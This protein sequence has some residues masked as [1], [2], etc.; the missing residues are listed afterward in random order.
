MSWKD[1]NFWDQIS[2]VGLL[3]TL[4]GLYFTTRKSVWGF[5]ITLWSEPF[6]FVTSYLHR[7]WSVFLV[8]VVYTCVLIHG[9]RKWKREE[10]KERERAL[11]A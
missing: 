6:W 8:T 7:Q 3:L 11:I 1:P 10:D 2:Q 9:I 4:V 5:V